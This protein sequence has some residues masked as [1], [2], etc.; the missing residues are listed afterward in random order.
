[1]SYTELLL[2]ANTALREIPLSNK[3]LVEKQTY[4][5][6]IYEDLAKIEPN[7]TP[8]VQKVQ[9]AIL[10]T[11][12]NIDVKITQNKTEYSAKCSGV[13][14]N[15][16]PLTAGSGQENTSTNNEWTI[17]KKN[18]M[19]FENVIGAVEAVG[20]IHEALI[21]PQRYAFL[22]SSM[23]LTPW[24]TVLLF[25]P[26]GTGKSMIARA[27]A[28]EIDATFFSVSCADVTSKWVGGSEKL[29]KA[30]FT[31]ARSKAPAIVFFD[32][33][34]SIARFRG[35]DSNIADQRLTNQLLLEMDNL[36]YE[37]VGIFVLA[38]TNVPWDIDTAV[39]RRFSKRI[40]VD[41]PSTTDRFK[42]LKELFSK[43]NSELN[44]EGLENIAAMTEGFSGSDI[45]SLV[46]D[47]AYLPLRELLLCESWRITR[48]NEQKDDTTEENTDYK[49][50]EY[51]DDTTEENAAYIV[52]MDTDGS[53][54]SAKYSLQ[55]IVETYGQD[56]IEIPK[57]SLKHVMHV[58]A[59]ARPTM[60]PKDL[61]R[62][63]DYVKA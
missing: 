61:Y 62:Y 23:S 36:H 57:I 50:E 20:A 41:V 19:S 55:Y 52:K 3:S 43:Y 18:S 1:M 38:A 60:Q 9:E 30:L 58:V 49:T 45:V 37:E 22:Y 21:Y 33:I 56:S 14:E 16:G 28:T 17:V 34:D 5:L 59:S 13:E 48:Q 27:T 53:E 31:D 51:A 42:I 54:N 40:F 25:G 8:D 32:E 29:L 63:K 39:L 46:Q 10:Q 11:C 47:C 7:T 24:R 44:T 35:S 26:P 15:L 6:G 12:E 4:L 2:K